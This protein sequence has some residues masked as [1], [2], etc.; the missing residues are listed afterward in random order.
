MGDEARAKSDTWAMAS[1]VLETGRN[2]TALPA[3]FPYWYAVTAF[4]IPSFQLTEMPLTYRH[5]SSFCSRLVLGQLR[6]LFDGVLQSHDSRGPSIQE[7]LPEAWQ[8]DLDLD[9]E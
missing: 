3:T 5:F 2:D 9:G 7:R 6:N 8:R 1:Q 4:E